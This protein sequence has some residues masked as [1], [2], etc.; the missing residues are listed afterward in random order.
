MP[1]K[2]TDIPDEEEQAL[3]REMIKEV[4]RRLRPDLVAET[5]AEP[6]PRVGRNDPCPCGS[7]RKYKRCHGKH[8][9]PRQE[10]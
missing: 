3:L 6:V 1:I 8:A 9:D 2:D 5:K 7:G 4:T 10:G